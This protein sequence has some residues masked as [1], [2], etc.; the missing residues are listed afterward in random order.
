MLWQVLDTGHVEVRIRSEGIDE[1]SAAKVQGDQLVANILGDLETTLGIEVT[2]D[3]LRYSFSKT[4]PE[5]TVI[6]KT[7][8]PKERVDDMRSYL[9]GLAEGLS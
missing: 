7:T 2:R 1:V 9:S 4:R 8:V 5:V 3:E 6:W